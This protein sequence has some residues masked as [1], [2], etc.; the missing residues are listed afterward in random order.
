MNNNTIWTERQ[1]AVENLRSFEAAHPENKM[2][3][4]DKEMEGR[5]NE[6]ILR[7]DRIMSNNAASAEKRSVLSPAIARFDAA[8]GSGVENRDAS[9]VNWLRSAKPGDQ[10]SY[11]LPLEQRAAILKSNTGGTTVPSRTFSEVVADR[12]NIGGLLAAGLT[13]VNTDGGEDIVVP[14]TLSRP[15]ASLTGEGSSI[16]ISDGTFSSATLSAYKYALISQASAELVSDNSADVVNYIGR[17]AG[18]ALNLALTDAVTNGTGAGQPEG[19]MTGTV[20]KTLD[21]AGVVT[22]DNCLEWFYSL[23]A[24]ERDGGVF[25]FSDTMALAL[26]KLK[27]TDDHYI[28]QQ[29]LSADEPDRFLGK[30]VITGSAAPTF[31]TTASAVLGAFFNPSGTMLRVAG[32][33]TAERSNEF[34]WQEDLISWKWRMRADSR[35][36]RPNSIA[37][38]VNP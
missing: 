37:T 35:I 5:M 8:S 36:V 11:S 33:L 13:V 38:L 15:V 20:G 31:D 18:D 4:A 27:G 23:P 25:Y 19:V 28:W 26:R 17:I 3:A 14:T 22:A 12:I 24:E 2:T 21:V 10:A 29:G 32:G 9:E 30:P 6:E 16:G 7:L 1:K 34:A